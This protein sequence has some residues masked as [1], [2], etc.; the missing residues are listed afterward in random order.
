MVS[1]SDH[2]AGAD[3]YPASLWADGALIR[4]TFTLRVPPDAPPGRYL[5]EIG[6]YDAAG[7]L[8]LDNGAD[9]LLLTQ[10]VVK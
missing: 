5:I 4:N 7:R 2:I 1:G 6:L 9:R 10:V 8:K 3:N